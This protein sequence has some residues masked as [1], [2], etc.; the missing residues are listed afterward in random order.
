MNSIKTYLL[1]MVLLLFV[2]VS[3]FGQ[4]SL[5]NET[6]DKEEIQMSKTDSIL[7]NCYYSEEEYNRIHEIN[8][9]E[10]IESSEE[11]YEDEIYNDK[12]HKKR[13]MGSF[14][15]DVPAELIVDVVAN[16]LF[17]IAILWQ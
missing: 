12:K 7:V 6:S 14:L 9:L 11:V 10:C 13:S 5:N 8:Q 1:L 15:V 17:F 4:S 16:T 3:S 2:T